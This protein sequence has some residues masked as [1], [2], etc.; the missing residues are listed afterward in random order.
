MRGRRGEKG[1][2]LLGLVV[3]MGI[4]MVLLTAAV[5]SWKYIV[6]DEREQELIF[7]GSEI[8]RAVERFQKK[9]GGAYPPSMEVL[10]KGKFLRRAYKD[11]FSADGKWRVLHPGD[12]QALLVAGR[13]GIGRGALQSPPPSPR[14]ATGAGTGTG[15]GLGP[16]IG[17]GTRTKGKSLRI[18]NGRD[19]YEDWAFVAGQPRVV[20]KMVTVLGSGVEPSSAPSGPAR[21][22][23]PPPSPSSPVPIPT[24]Q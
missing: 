19:R 17:V 7:R 11:P 9:S 10:V 4:M 23:S 2:S 24:P 6:Q 8:A 14:P 16:V 21:S 15:E 20:G 1:V 22:P 18:F 3:A 13:Q 5:P 12:L